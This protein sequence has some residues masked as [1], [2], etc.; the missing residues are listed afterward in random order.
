MSATHTMEQL[1]QSAY[2]IV[3]GSKNAATGD[4][5]TAFVDLYRDWANDYISELELETDW[6]WWRVQD[7]TFGQASNDD[8]LP[9]PEDFRKLVVNIERPVYL[10]HDGTVISSFV[11]VDPNNVN[12]PPEITKE[13]RVTYIDGKFVFSR[14]F[15]EEELGADVVGD[16]MQY[17]PEITEVT[18]ENPNGD[19][20]INVI[21]PFKLLT[22]GMA[23]DISL[24]DL[25]QGG[26]S[27]NIEQRYLKVLGEAVAQNAQSIAT[28]SADFSSYGDIG[29]V[30]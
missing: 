8:P 25:V 1:A 15:R 18:D 19:A 22:L 5:L 6:I 20:V 30:Y 29:G 28:G 24:P 3:N 9:V 10:M 27:P 7:F 4:A 11:V 2:R 23:K 12:N 13:D 14:P 26:I 16:Y 21:Q 17:A